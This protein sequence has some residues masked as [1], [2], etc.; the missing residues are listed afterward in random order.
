M[1]FIIS[2]TPHFSFTNL[3]G[4]FFVVYYILYSG[5]SITRLILGVLGF[6]FGH[7][8][9]YPDFSALPLSVANHPKSYHH[10]NNAFQHRQHRECE[11]LR[12]ADCGNM[13]AW[14]YGIVPFPSFFSIPPKFLSQVF[15]SNRPL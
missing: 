6:G 11:I 13:E 5:G 8:L 12:V 15:C 4:I 14:N 3:K 7:Q 9:Q 2:T 10:L 1:I